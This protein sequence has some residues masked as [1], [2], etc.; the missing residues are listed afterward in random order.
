M[1]LFKNND[2]ELLEKINIIFQNQMKETLGKSFEKYIIQF[3][4]L[5][6]EE[7]EIIENAAK[8][9]IAKLEKF[10]K[11]ER[12]LLHSNNVNIELEN[13]IKSRD[14]IIYRKT[15]QIDQMNRLNKVR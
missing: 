8:E 14:S 6:N 7:K 3:Q 2:D 12:Q 10:E 13:K 5:V 1:A 15:K 9:V 11:L 4:E